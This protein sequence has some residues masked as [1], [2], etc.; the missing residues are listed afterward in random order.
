MPN[1]EGPSRAQPSWPDKSP[2]FSES[3]FMFDYI[4][5]VYIVF[6]EDS[7]PKCLFGTGLYSCYPVKLTSEMSCANLSTSAQGSPVAPKIFKVHNIG[8]D[9]ASSF[10]PKTTTDL[11]TS[12][13]NSSSHFGGAVANLEDYD[14]EEITDQSPWSTKHNGSIRGTHANASEEVAKS[15]RASYNFQLGL[16]NTAAISRQYNKSVPARESRETLQHDD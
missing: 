8:R 14:D 13:P 1:H 11:G 4:C 10:T 9:F 5:S 7:E 12:D 2:C 6:S 16:I 15:N 3:D